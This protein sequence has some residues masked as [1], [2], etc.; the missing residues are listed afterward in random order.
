MKN[1]IIGLPKKA[2]DPEGD[3]KS[4]LINRI[5]NKYPYLTPDYE[6][7]PK[8]AYKDISYAGPEDGIGF[9][10]SRYNDVTYCGKC[11]FNN[12]VFNNIPKVNIYDD[13]NEAMRM[14]DNFAKPKNPFYKPNYDYKDMFGRPVKVYDNFIQVGYDIIPKY[15][16][17]K[18]YENISEEIKITITDI[19]ISIKKFMF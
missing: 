7:K 4:F 10:L 17:P 3:L 2:Q 13:F 1:F 9:G 6:N 19:T 14:L 15:I 5:A 12:S 8:W 11:P 16:T 18:Y